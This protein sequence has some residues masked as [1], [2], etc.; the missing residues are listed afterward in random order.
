MQEEIKI[1]SCFNK[2]VI[3]ENFSKFASL[4][5]K[6]SSL[7]RYIA[8]NLCNSHLYVP[9]RSIL[10]IGCGTGYYTNLLLYKFPK[11]HI[12][13]FDF[14]IKMLDIAGK[15]LNRNKRVYLL[16][17]DAEQI[18]FNTKY[19]LITSNACLQWIYDLALFCRNYRLLLCPSGI[20]SFSTFGPETLK[21]LSCV[22]EKVFGRNIGLPA[23]EF[24]EKDGIK[25]ILENNFY[26]VKIREEKR[27]EIYSTIMDL[28]HTI[29]YSGERGV[30][31]NNTNI[32]FSPKLIK[33]MDDLYTKLFK[34]IQ[35]TYQIFYC[36]AEA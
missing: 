2:N 10:E 3:A 23:Q 15:R 33:E 20:I 14:S 17:A 18:F 13:S 24:K 29:K 8:D 7:Q 9:Y 19:N 22:M 12:T 27:Q 26:N 36:R 31:L 32:S 28:L 11:S 35:V 5:D 1:N 25:R 6:N 4:Y 30:S 21:E 16:A 34:K